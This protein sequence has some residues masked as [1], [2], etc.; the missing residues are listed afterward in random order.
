MGFFD[1]FSS[2]PTSKKIAKAKSVM[3][4]EHHQLQ[5]RQESIQELIHYGTDEA[6]EALIDRL[7]VN[8]R[9]TTKNEQEQSWI[10][11]VLVEHFA[12]RSIDLLKKFITQSES[13]S[14]SRAIF[15]LK[16]LIGQE[17]MTVFLITSLERFDPK[18]HR[19][20]ETRLQV[21][22]ALDEQPGE[23]IESILPYVMDHNDDVRIKVINLIEDRIIGIEGE[24]EYII[25]AFLDAMTDPYAGGRI[26][27]AVAQSLIRLEVNLSGYENEIKD[28]MPDGYRLVNG[29][30]K[31]V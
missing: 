1:M 12:E 9:D 6:I 18:D 14:L 31:R 28:Q 13:K 8:F 30:I 23:I 26:T 15:T 20:V 4:N 5:V 11:Q 21:I 19:T 3:L 22:D 17:E 27:R 25:R 24:Y 2:K 16:S 29:L 7:G 10:Q